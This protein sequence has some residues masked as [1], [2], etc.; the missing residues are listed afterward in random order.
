MDKR[1]L[2]IMLVMKHT[3]RNNKKKLA[4]WYLKHVATLLL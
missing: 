3:E 1:P 2:S 4:R